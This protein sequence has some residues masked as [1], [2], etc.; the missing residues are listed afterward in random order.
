MNIFSGLEK[1][2]ETNY[3]LANHTWYGLG[4]PADYFIRP[5]NIKQLKEVV[6]RCNENGIRIY[7]I[8]F[9]SNLLIS[10]DGLK[11]AV[12][13]LQA[14][15]FKQTQIEGEMVTAWAGADLSKLVLSCVQKGLSGIE[16]LTGIPGSIGGAVKMNAG[17]NF[18]DIGSSVETITLMDNQGNIFEKSK[19]ELRFDYRQTN[20]TA[21]FILNASLNLTEGDPEQ[22]M[23][24]VKEI[25]IYKK[26][27]QPLNTKNSGCIF[28]NPRG[29]SA[30]ALIDRAGLKGLKIGG[31][32]VSEKHANFIIAEKDCT[33]RDVMR[34][35]DA[36]KERVKEQ[37]DTELELEIEIWS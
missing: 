26:N 18:G 23:R 27:N 6:R 37:F 15:Q 24:T 3:P 9:G 22:I 4:G 17:G 25:W 8:G 21:K 16:A 5:Q 13:T 29:V 31:A 28:K 10:D 20:I 7:V 12:I 11:A 2:V 33:S 14:D 35:I 19:P 34:L 1:I 32:T 36:I 30:G